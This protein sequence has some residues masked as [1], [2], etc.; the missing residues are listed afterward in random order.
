MTT[1]DYIACLSAGPF[2]GMTDP[3]AE[4]GHYFSQ[5][6][7]GIIA[8]ILAQIWQPLLLRGYHVS[9]EASLQ[10]SELR[11]PDLAV[12]AR[13]Q[14]APTTALNYA[15][16]AEA[17]QAEPGEQIDIDEPEWQAV[18][19][20]LGGDLVTVVEVISPRNKSHAADILRY[21]AGRD[22]L[23]LAN[24]VNVVEIDLTRSVKR[25][26]EHALTLRHPYYAAVF[27]PADA[28]RIIPMKIGEALKRIALPLRDDVLAV[29]LQQVYDTAYREATIAAQIAARDGYIP[30]SL[31][32]PSLLTEEERGAALDAVQRWQAKL[33]QLRAE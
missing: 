20:H 16:A 12:F 30:N 2:A 33:T 14:P 6:H 4:D 31:P 7:S 1:S 21:Q 28:P 32:F 26:V 10:I 22:G 25:L 27:L 29:E 17:V 8:A 24:G 15:T 13:S 11:K 3:W 19:L 18:H 5:L 9:K 23:F